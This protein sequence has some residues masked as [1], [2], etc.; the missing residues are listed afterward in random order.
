VIEVRPVRAD[1]VP[2]VISLVAEVLSEFGLSF[3]Q[4]SPTDDQLRQLPTS[5]AD[6]GGAF[7][8]A[9]SG[10]DLLGTAGVFPVD[11]RMYELRKMYLRPASRGLGL[12]TRLLDTVVEFVRARGGTH[13]V[14]DTIEE[15]TRAIAF[16]EANGF[17]RDDTQKRAERCSRGYARKL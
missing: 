17:V 14:L 13:V 16:Y 8:V 9:F 12:G 2:A 5:Y 11:A 3:G 10:G 1:D 7:W 4:G 15:M 6:H